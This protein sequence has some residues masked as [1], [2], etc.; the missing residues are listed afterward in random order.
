MKKINFKKYIPH[1][2]ILLASILISIPIFKMNLSSTNE[3]RIHIGRIVAI[4]KLIKNNIFPALISNNNMNGFG[5]AL[6][7]FYGPITTYIPML[8]SYKSI[9]STGIQLFTLISIIASG[10]TMYFYTLKITK[11]KIAATCSALMYILLPYKLTNIYSRNALGE[12]SASIFLPLLLSGLYELTEGNTKKAYLI[13][14]SA[15]GLILSHTITT[16]YA[17]IF[18]IIYLI[19]FYRKINLNKIKI[20]LINIL[21]AILVASFYWIPLMEYKSS[22]KYAIFSE[23][24]MNTTGSDVYENTTNFD[25]LFEN[26]I[27]YKDRDGNSY[28]TLALGIMSVTLLLFSIICYNKVE[29]NI[30]MI[31]I[32]F[33]IFTV[34]SLWMTTKLFPWQIMPNFMTVIQFA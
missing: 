18:S 12:Y 14:L 29:K 8:L 28:P 26:E 32:L 33:I 31:Y 16:I 3:F 5:Y 27:N 21:I 25:S 22:S 9:A 15:I 4:S 20:L 23:N 13:A 6:N 19:A 7:I 11:N 30:K 24:I 10:Y 17:S 1:L 2:I 34:I